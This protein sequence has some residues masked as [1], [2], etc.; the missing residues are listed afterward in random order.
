VPPAAACRLI[1][2]RRTLIVDFRV[3]AVLAALATLACVAASPVAGNLLQG[4]APSRV[5]QVSD[6]QRLT[7][8][9][10]AAEGDGW[11]T[12]LTSVFRGGD[13]LVEWDLGRVVPIRALFLQG[14]N[15][16]EFFVSVSEDGRA[17][18]DLY[19]A[20]AVTG[21]GMRARFTN[22]LDA[23]GRHVRLTARG[24]D[25]SVSASELLLFE[26]PPTPFPPALQS[27]A[28]SRAWISG[29]REA[30]AFGA[31]LGLALLL[32]RRSQ[33]R[34]LRGAAWATLVVGSGW[35]LAAVYAGAPP[36]KPPPQP[37][38]DMTR[39]VAAAVAAVAVLR[40]TLSP[41]DVL[42]RFIDAAL[43]ASALLALTTFY[44]MGYP[45]FA[46]V[47]EG[48]RTWV[49]TW[50]MRVYFP[51]AKYFD[52]LGYDGLYLA[53]VKA[54]LEDAPGASPAAVAR[55]PLRDLNSYQMT[56]AAQTMDSI[57]AIPE[58][59]TPQR[60]AEFKRDM[61]FFWR[62]MGPGYLGSLR[63]HGGNAT[64]AWLLV[65]WAIFGKSTASEATLAAAAW[66]DPL[67]LLGFFL[68]A[69]K[70]FGLRTALICVVAYGASAFPWLNSNW[71]GS[72]LRN[73]WMV[74]V[75]LGACALKS[76]RWALGG[77]LLAGSAMI[78]AFPAL[79]VLFLVVPTGWWVL[80]KWRRDRRLPSI[81]RLLTAQRPLLR[82]LTGAAAC[83]AVLFALSG[84]RF[85]FAHSWGDWSQ[86]IALHSVSPNANHVGLRALFQYS[87]DKTLSALSATGGD[88]SLE[89]QRTLQQRKP[90]FYLAMLAALTLA[91]WAARGRD[92]R[93]ASLIGMLLIPFL[94]YPSNYYLHY[95]FVLPLLVDPPGHPR[96][97][98]LWGVVTGAVLLLCVSE[99]WGFEARG[100]DERYVQ[101]SAGAILAFAA[102]LYALVRDGRAPGSV[103][104][105]TD[106][107]SNGGAMP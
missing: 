31:L 85:G 62:T 1:E 32:H 3:I 76:G 33:P 74:L 25:R 11:K 35:M 30:L 59:F 101:W 70:T 5:V 93:Q 4:R 78:R 105:R 89:Q 71:A 97:R 84:L 95:V 6:S 18:H 98:R 58:R 16:D 14:D 15:N 91:L 56:T 9:I 41:G 57:R 37:V 102:I 43:G 90:F 21:A 19:A 83:V 54:Y 69:A 29:E 8:G 50:D 63:D 82:A 46:N 44:N 13:A 99:Y 7:D 10:T 49:H 81:S 67:L 27:R 92:L 2:V 20:K 94:F 26:N 104:P 40:L 48:R 52:E 80:E 34:L 106:Q 17:F 39:A 100:A 28:G 86:K 60:W 64:P 65:A 53:S 47:A 87:P 96:Q 73:D 51:T 88:W 22:L 36:G 42:P 23:R 55:T 12:D 79:A 45:Q 75:G 103:T 107:S 66:L 77:A 24:G 61:A 68:V 72:T 38:I